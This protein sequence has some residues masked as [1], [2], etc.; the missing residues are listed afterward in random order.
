MD[1][2]AD[3]RLFLR[4][5]ATG[6]LSA[7]GRDLGLSPGAVSQRLKSL[8]ERYAAPLLTRSSRAI[9]LTDEGRTFLQAAHS[10][11]SEADALDFALRTKSH[12][13]VGRLRVAAPCDFGRQ[14]V[15][16]LLVEFGEANPNLCVEFFL[17]DAIDDVIRQDFDVVFRYGN[18]NDSSLIGRSIAANRRVL[19]ASPE[20]LALHGTPTTPEEL[21]EHKC[22]ILMRGTERLD[23]WT[24]V[25]NGEETVQ[26]IYAGFAVNDGEALRR[27][28]LAGRGVA[29]KS[30]L[31]VKGDLESGHLVEVLGNYVPRRVGAQIL[32]SAARR[33]TPRVRA[34]VDAAV[35]RCNEIFGS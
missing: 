30:V 6:S 31:D 18:L 2:L 3:M 13:L 8:E 7:A 25:V 34:F 1:L 10:V 23:H 15:E 29:M 22:L 16:P 24:F 28:A 27:W 4:I 26:S 33:N 9:A 21:V 12:G 14:V 20:Y 17:S 11:I 32:F 35:S 5:V 19:V